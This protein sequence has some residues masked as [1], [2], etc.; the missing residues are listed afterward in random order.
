MLTSRSM[1]H[2]RHVCLRPA[3]RRVRPR[4]EGRWDTPS[5]EEGE[6]LPKIGRV[7]EVSH[8]S[9]S[10]RF[11]RGRLRR[12]RLAWRAGLPAGIQP[13]FV[14]AAV[15]F[16]L[17]QL[18]GCAHVFSVSPLPADATA[19]P[20]LV[21]FWRVAGPL[22]LGSEATDSRYKDA[23]LVMGRR[24]GHTSTP[25]GLPRV[26]DRL[27]DDHRELTALFIGLDH[28]DVLHTGRIER[29]RT[30]TLGE[31]KFASVMERD[32]G[33]PLE[34]PPSG[35]QSGATAVPPK[36]DPWLLMV[37]ELSDPSTVRVWVLDPLEVAEDVKSQRISGT[38]QEFAPPHGMEADD[39]LL[40]Y[41]T[42][43][44][45]ELKTYFRNDAAR[46]LGSQ[47]SLVLRRV[48]PE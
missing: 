35:R 43:D 16:A 7:A 12:R 23:I 44:T 29:I 22:P 36:G 37:Y 2:P 41:L 45:P 47:P 3:P 32:T 27:G 10:E 21:G 9:A 28:R 15:G 11:R 1:T 17:V 8:V 30:T 18:A 25:Y 33:T 26:R 19:D 14:A 13:V 31:R 24:G 4:D 40:V 38:V 6:D 46:L 34:P 5:P 42:A 20:G 39:Q 48:A